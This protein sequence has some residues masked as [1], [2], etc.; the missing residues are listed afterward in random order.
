MREELATITLESAL[1]LLLIA[2]VFTYE[3]V[4]AGPPPSWTS[5]PGKQLLWG[6]KQNRGS[7]VGLLPAFVQRT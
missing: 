3:L 7:H 5:C 1:K 6:T 4:F 2:P